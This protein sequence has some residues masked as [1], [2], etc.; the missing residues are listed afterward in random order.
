M[1][2]PANPTEYEYLEGSIPSEWDGNAAGRGATVLSLAG[3][4][5]GVGVWGRRSGIG[6]VMPQQTHEVDVLDGQME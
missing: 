3:A 6:M 1:V 5:A 4:G 2:E